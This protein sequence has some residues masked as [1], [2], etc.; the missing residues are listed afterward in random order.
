MK[1]ENLPLDIKQIFDRKKVK[2][3][4]YDIAGMRYLAKNFIEYLLECQKNEDKK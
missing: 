4:K 3:T 1:T 2:Y